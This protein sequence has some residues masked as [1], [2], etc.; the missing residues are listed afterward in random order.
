MYRLF[1]AALFGAAIVIL[2]AVWTDV[3]AGSTLA[4]LMVTIAGTGL[5]V[6]STVL[7]KGAEVATG[8]RTPW[9]ISAIS[10]VPLVLGV[11]AASFT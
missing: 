5:G 2:C 11:L 3:V 9:R 1:T 8:V 4:T 6:V 7:P 10:T